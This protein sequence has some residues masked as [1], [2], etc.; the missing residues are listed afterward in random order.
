MPDNYYPENE[1]AGTGAAAAPP[2]PKSDQ[3][4]ESAKGQT[5]LLPKSILAGKEFNPGDEVVLKIVR[6]Y[7]NEVEVEYAT[8][9]EEEHPNQ[10][11]SEPSAD[12]TAAEGKLESM[13]E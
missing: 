7:E 11:M 2:A 12:M 10:P 8:G 5:A 1:E 6:L 9:E 13:A 4:S 3:E